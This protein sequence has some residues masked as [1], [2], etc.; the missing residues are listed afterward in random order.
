[1]TVSEGEDELFL[2]LLALV[3]VFGNEI[4]DKL[5]E[6]GDTIGKDVEDDVDA[7]D[8]VEEEAEAEAEGDARV[9]FDDVGEIREDFNIMD[10]GDDDDEDDDDDDDGLNDD[11]DDFEDEDA[12]VDDRESDFLSAP[13]G[14]LSL[15]A[16]F[17][18]VNDVRLLL[19]LLSSFGSVLRVSDFLLSDRLIEDLDF[20]E[21]TIRFSFDFSAEALSFFTDCNDLSATGSG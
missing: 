12:V 4:L 13:I 15:G 16:F 7:D 10:D 20:S 9:D 2:L 3:G 19:D 6:D 5:D 21:D 1:M 11:V 14:L 17:D 18:E 8:E